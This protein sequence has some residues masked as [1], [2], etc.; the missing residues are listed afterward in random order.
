VR[1]LSAPHHTAPL[2]YR[3]ISRF[4]PERGRFRNPGH[5]LV[6]LTVS[7]RNRPA[8]RRNSHL[9]GHFICTILPANPPISPRQYRTAKLNHNP[10][11]HE[12]TNQTPKALFSLLYNE[13]RE[14]RFTRISAW[15]DTPA[16]LPVTPASTYCARGSS[17]TCRLPRLRSLTTE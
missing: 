10:Y 13:F 4:L 3:V 9:S 8:F 15:G 17:L 14:S 11:L 7:P 16:G 5:E 2:I 12:N 1:R 6:V